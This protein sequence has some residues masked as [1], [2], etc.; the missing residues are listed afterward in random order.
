MAAASQANTGSTPDICQRVVLR[1]NPKAGR[2]ECVFTDETSI[3]LPGFLASFLRAGDT[4]HFSLTAPAEGGSREIYI[5]RPRPR[6]REQDFL[7]AE[8]GYARQ[9]REDARNIPAV[10]ADVQGRYLGISAVQFRCDVL[11]DYFHV[12]DRQ[13]GW[14][15]QPSFY[16]LLRV[17]SNVSPTELR[18]AFKLRSLEVR[19]SNGPTDHIHSLERA[20]NILAQP[21]LRESYDKLLGDPETAVSFPYGGFGSLFV[22]GALSR[23]ERTFF[24]SRIL[25]FRPQQ[26]AKLIRAALRNC[27]FYEHLALYRDSRRKLEV[28]LDRGLMPLLWE[29]SWNRWKHL[30]G[31][32]IGIKAVFVQAGRY[33]YHKTAWELRTWEVALPSR[34]EVTLP[35][36]I[37]G[38]IAETQKNYQRFGQFAESLEQIRSRLESTPVERD[39]LRRLCSSVGIPVDFDVSLITWKPDYEDF[40]YKQLLRRARHLYLFRSEYVF[41]LEP[42]VVVETPQLGH[43]T[44]LFSKPA[45]MQDFLARYRSITRE[46]ILQNRTNA[47]EQLGFLCRLIHGQNPQTW[48]AELKARLGEVP[49]SNID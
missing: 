42:L 32:R 21:E 6:Y 46:D 10:T 47:A 33:R 20:F 22:S 1:T 26:S 25:S 14:D 24:V 35:E 8:I 38:Q 23:D 12:A 39:E 41:D 9:P 44:Y 27:T 31:T 7:L 30:L 2:S 29:P 36:G 45:S 49:G 34:I 3:L 15:R 37:A 4:L 16:E 11:R 48:L 18:I 13:R 28:S 19:T 5:H 43:A 17:D 40:Y